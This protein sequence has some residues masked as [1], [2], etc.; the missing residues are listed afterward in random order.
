M[1]IR[2]ILTG[3]AAGMTHAAIS[4]LSSRVSGGTDHW[5]HHLVGG[6]AAGVVA[7][8]HGSSAIRLRRAAVFAVASVLSKQYAVYTDEYPDRHFPRFGERSS[9]PYF[10]LNHRFM[11]P[12]AK[13]HEK[14]LEEKL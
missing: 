2:W 7:G 1:S 5:V 4:C 6:A 9:S 13:M 12:E 14:L 3:I 8:I 11:N 10:T